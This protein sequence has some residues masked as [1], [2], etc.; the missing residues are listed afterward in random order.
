MRY[1]IF[2]IFSVS[3]LF[4]SCDFNKKYYYVEDSKEEKLIEASSDSAA[5]ME[6]YTNFQISKKVYRDMNQSMG[7]VTLSEPISFSLLD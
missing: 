7:T 5:Y 6:A 1:S 2:F 4:F 3:I